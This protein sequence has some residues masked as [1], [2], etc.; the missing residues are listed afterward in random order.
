MLDSRCQRKKTEH[1]R[2]QCWDSFGPEPIDYFRLARY[3]SGGM[4]QPIL[5]VGDRGM[6]GRAFRELLA[7][8]GRAYHGLDL[9]AFDEADPK[10][11]AA[12][13]ERPWSGLINCARLHERRRRRGGRGLGSA[14]ERDRSWRGA[15][16]ESK[17]FFERRRTLLDRIMAA[18]IASAQRA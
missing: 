18:P 13:F 11:V 1:L 3:L 14:R 6:L 17:R 5:L 10:Q 15:I 7:R 9:P 4:N 16:G 8:E 12:I 2:R